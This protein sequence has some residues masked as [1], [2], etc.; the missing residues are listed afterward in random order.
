[1]NDRGRWR[2]RLT[3]T[4]PSSATVRPSLG[5]LRFVVNGKL[6][7]AAEFAFSNGILKPGWRSLASNQSVSAERRLGR[8]LFPSPGVYQIE[9]RDP[10]GA[11]AAKHRVVVTP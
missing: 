5:A 6:A 7:Y 8:S 3:A 9:L 1:M 10:S 11:T 4:N 2:L